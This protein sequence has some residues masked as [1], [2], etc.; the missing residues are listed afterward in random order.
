MNPV[1][2]L[3]DFSKSCARVSLAAMWLAWPLFGCGL[4]ATGSIS[5]FALV[6]V[7]QSVPDLAVFWIVALARADWR[8]AAGAAVIF[9]AIPLSFYLCVQAYSDA[10]PWIHGMH[11]WPLPIRYAKFVQFAI[12]VSLFG[13]VSLPLRMLLRLRLFRIA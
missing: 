5:L 8:S 4:E 3:G 6:T 1:T 13:L 11:G 9:V 2:S 7:L 12:V 10:N